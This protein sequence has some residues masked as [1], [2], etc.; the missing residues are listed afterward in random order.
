LI[1]PSIES[2]SFS[3]E[4]RALHVL[5]RVA[6]GPRPGDFNY[7]KQMGVENW[8]KRQLDPF[9]FLSRLTYGHDLLR[10]GR[11]I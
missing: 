7:V 5:N 2:G 1:R 11:S 10:Y 3:Y 4:Q 6:F 8:L 9:Q